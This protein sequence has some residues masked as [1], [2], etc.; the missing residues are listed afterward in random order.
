MSDSLRELW[1]RGIAFNAAAPADVL[2]CLLDEAAGEAG[3][4]MCEGRD[5]P[6]A[7]IDAALRHPVERIRRALARNLHVD[8][9]RL[10]PL[11]SDPSGLVR[12][13]LARGT[14]L[15]PRWVRPLPADILVTFLT[16]QDGGEDGRVTEKDIVG[17]LWSSRQV[18]PSFPRDMAGHDH[19]A[20]RLYAAFQWQSLTAAQRK[21][22][23]DDPDPA[24][25]DAARKSSRQLDPEAVEAELPPI[26]SRH[27]VS[28]LSTCALSPAVVEQCF[29]DDEVHPLARNRHTPADALARLARHPDAEIRRLVATRPDLG[30]AAAELRQDPDED[31]RMRARL[32]PF[33]RTWAEFQEV[34]K[35]VD[36]GPDC[37]C[38]IT[39]PATEPSP[40]WYA[41]CA[42][43]EEPVLRRVAA[44]WPGLPAELVGTLA[45]DDDEEVRIQLA[46]HHPLAPPHLLLD[47]F[48]TRPAH[49]P[50]LL[51]LPA[52]PRTGRTHLIG[53]PD[54][55]VRALAA[56]DPT[57]TE[58]PLEDP[59]DA[60]RRAAAANP[61]L[62]PETLETLLTDPRTAE[63]AAANPSLPRP[64][65]A[66]TPRPLPERRRHPADGGPTLRDDIHVAITGMAIAVGH[67]LTPARR[68]S[69]SKTPTA[70]GYLQGQ[71]R[72]VPG[73][74]A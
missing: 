43:S 15:Q 5:L 13:Y 39:Q 24:V 53:H 56:A 59:D 74:R 32:Q 64:P 3:L 52:F 31:V 45:L 42:A 9:A 20:L 30:P 35:V 73:E 14:R 6:D 69:V 2:I 51:T 47:V 55:E 27:A 70:P 17:E 22:L 49:R 57:L 1:L 54:P 7:V 66:R 10:A 19:P 18:P 63:G 26:G 28:V 46:C 11:A 48:V 40:D 71:H 67:R 16:A 37:T 58:P 33:I 25:Q 21:A 50:H 41:T 68:A 38:P 60:V 72:D 29:A 4:L 44:S 36:H 34:H 12:A 8:P 23:L 65:H 61:T 62:T